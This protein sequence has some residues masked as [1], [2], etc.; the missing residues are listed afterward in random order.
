LIYSS[1][2]FTIKDND[3]VGSAYPCRDKDVWTSSIP[4]N[5]PVSLLRVI[6]MFTHTFSKKEKA[7][8]PDGSTEPVHIAVCFDENM[9]MPFLALAESLRYSL[10]NRYITLIIHVI[11]TAVSFQRPYHV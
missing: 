6:C 4:G 1:N 7:V 10:K 11:Y 3:N 5:P 8:E 2:Q 9:D